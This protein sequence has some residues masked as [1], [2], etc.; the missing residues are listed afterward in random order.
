MASDKIPKVGVGVIIVKDGKVLMGRRQGDSSHSI[1]EWCPSGGKLD[2][3]ESFA[4]CAKR[5]VKEEC[6][7]EISEPELVTCTNDVI[8]GDNHFV[9]VYVKANW[10]SGEPKVLEPNKMAEWAWFNWSNLPQPL[11]LPMQNLVKSGFS[12]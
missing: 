4:E 10:I 5:E 2:F 1:G 12:I 3:G 7:L 8:D 6:G 9:T 11:F